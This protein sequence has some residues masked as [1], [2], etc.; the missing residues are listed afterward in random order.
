MRGKILILTILM[1]VL[2]FTVTAS[3]GDW[4]GKT[5]I[6]I[7]GPLFTPFDDHFGPEPFRTGLMGS[8]FIKQ[9]LSSSIVLA[10]SGG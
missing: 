8:L 9:G 4:A 3:A 7:R 5:A 10:L 2:L 1:G 6:G